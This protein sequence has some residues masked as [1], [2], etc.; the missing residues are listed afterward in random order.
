MTILS[1][2]FF[3]TALIYS[4]VGFGGGSTYLALLLLWGVPYHI[5]PIIALV[6]NIIVVSGNS[7]NYS[8]AGN[9]NIKLLLPYL[10]GSIPFAF[11][12]GSIQ[13]EKELFEI[14]LFFV[15][16]IAGGLLLI[17]FKSYDNNSANYKVL[18]IFH[19]QD[20]QDLLIHLIYTNFLKSLTKK[21]HCR[22]LVFL[23]LH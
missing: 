23:M 14:I 17:N 20:F 22:C 8:R 9:L 18:P 10:L 19:V 4:S 5:F 7:F 13:I 16:G 1:I 11:I 12:G 2:L 15:L 6:C 21:L 3:V